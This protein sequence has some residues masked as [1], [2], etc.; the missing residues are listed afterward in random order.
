MFSHL[1]RNDI[2]LCEEFVHMEHSPHKRCGS[3]AQ[4]WLSGAGCPLG[5]GTRDPRWCRGA[6][7]L[8]KI[9]IGILIAFKYD[10]IYKQHLKG[11]INKITQV[12]CY[13]SPVLPTCADTKRLNLGIFWKHFAFYISICW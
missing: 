9:L 10:N 6:A 7:R 1:Q 4:A 2:N 3:G 12:K 8:C 5:S 13:S 11:V